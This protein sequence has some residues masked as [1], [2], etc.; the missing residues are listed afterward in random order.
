MIFTE[1]YFENIQAT[2]KREL[3]IAKLTVYAAV[4]WFTD[5]VLFETLIDIQQRKVQTQLCIVEDDI[6]FS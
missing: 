1:A 4:A 2:I 3:L 5:V 6:N